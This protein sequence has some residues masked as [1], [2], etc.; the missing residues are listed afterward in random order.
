MFLWRIPLQHRGWCECKLEY[1][2]GKITLQCIEV[3]ANDWAFKTCHSDTHGRGC[4]DTTFYLVCPR[5][6]SQTQFETLMNML[7]YTTCVYLRKKLYKLVY[8]RHV[9]YSRGYTPKQQCQQRH[10][11]SVCDCFSEYT[12]GHLEALLMHWVNRFASINTSKPYSRFASRLPGAHITKQSWYL[13]LMWYID[14][15]HIFK[16]GEKITSSQGYLWHH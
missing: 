8:Q 11:E 16:R 6:Y 15:F 7:I 13:I 3:Y 14:D 10:V 1:R 12:T 5:Q 2:R 4:K 9:G